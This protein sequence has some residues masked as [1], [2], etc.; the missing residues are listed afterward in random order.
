M[1][2]HIAGVYAA[3]YPHNLHSVCLVCPHGIDHEHQNKLIREAKETQK[4]KLLPQTLNE[5]RDMF[6]WLTYKDVKIPELFLYGI[7]QMRL[8][9]NDFF[10]MRMF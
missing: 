8:E 4:S 7:L 1:G 10:R 5:L 3:Q 9:K 2:G 6:E